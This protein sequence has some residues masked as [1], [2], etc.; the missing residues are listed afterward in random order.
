MTRAIGLW[1]FWIALLFVALVIAMARP[2][3]AYSCS[4]VRYYVAAYGAS[5]A[6]RWARKNLSRSQIR[7]ARAC[8]RGRR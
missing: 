8:L 6:L 7:A 3:H 2:V 5:A 1:Y 4:T